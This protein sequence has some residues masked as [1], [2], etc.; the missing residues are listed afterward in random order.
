MQWA[1]QVVHCTCTPLTTVFLATQ[2][3]GVVSRFLSIFS[4]YV[5]LHK[6]S[7]KVYYWSPNLRSPYYFLGILFKPE[8]SNFDCFFFFFFFQNTHTGCFF[9]PHQCWQQ[10]IQ[11]WICTRVK[12]V[13]LPLP[14]L[15][16][17]IQK[18]CIWEFFLGGESQGA[19]PVWNPGKGVWCMCE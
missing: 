14:L 18:A 7:Y 19:P 6:V 13:S 15:T 8:K 12:F 4:F 16:L 9:P 3:G 17:H 11:S 1:H 10:K 2:N 5:W